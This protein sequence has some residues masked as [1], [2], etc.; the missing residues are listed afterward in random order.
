MKK[1][2]RDCTYDDVRKTCAILKGNC[3]KCSLFHDSAHLCGYPPSMLF[4]ED[5][6]LEID[7][8]EEE[9]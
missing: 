4:E 2:L 1:K 5:L 7:I 9:Q 6:D 8:P 3:D